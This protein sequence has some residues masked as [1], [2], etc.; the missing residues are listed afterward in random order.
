MSDKVWTR[1]DPLQWIEADSL[2][3]SNLL[4]VAVDPNYTYKCYVVNFPY[5]DVTPKVVPKVKVSSQV[6]LRKHISQVEHRRSQLPGGSL[7]SDL[8]LILWDWILAIE[9]SPAHEEAI[10]NAVSEVALLA[11]TLPSSCPLVMAKVNMVQT[12]LQKPVVVRDRKFGSIVGFDRMGAKDMAIMQLEQAGVST[13]PVKVIRPQTLELYDFNFLGHYQNECWRFIFYLWD[14]GRVSSSFSRDLAA[15]ESPMALQPKFGHT[16]VNPNMQI[17]CE[18]LQ[19][20]SNNAFKRVAVGVSPCC[21]ATGL[22]KSVQFDMY[23]TRESWGTLL[24]GLLKNAR[25]KTRCPLV[26]SISC[27]LRHSDD[28]STTAGSL[29]QDSFNSLTG[30]LLSLNEFATSSNTDGE[31]YVKIRSAQLV[32]YSVLFVAFS[33]VDQDF[34]LPSDSCVVELWRGTTHLASC[35]TNSTTQYLKFYRGG[36]MLWKIGCTIRRIGPAPVPLP[37]QNIIEQKHLHRSLAEVRFDESLLEHFKPFAHALI[38]LLSLQDSKIHEQA[39]ANLVTLFEMVTLLNKPWYI[40]LLLPTVDLKDSENF[41]VQ[42]VALLKY[43]PSVQ[44]VVSQLEAIC[45]LLQDKSLPFSLLEKFMCTLGSAFN[46][47]PDVQEMLLRNF[48]NVANLSGP[49]LLIACLD[50]FKFDSAT[51]SVE[52]E[53]LFLLSRLSRLPLGRHKEFTNICINWMTQ[54]WNQG[55]KQWY[56]FRAVTSIMIHPGFDEFLP[57]IVD[58]AAV[59]CREKEFSHGQIFVCQREDA[60]ENLGTLSVEF[61]LVLFN[62]L[63]GQMYSQIIESLGL[64]TRN[65]IRILA[66]KILRLCQFYLSNASF[67]N[68]WYTLTV[69]KLGTL[70]KLL[71][72]LLEILSR[73]FI[74]RDVRNFDSSLW[75]DLINSICKLILAPQ[76]HESSLSTSEKVC[77]AKTLPGTSDHALELLERTWEMLAPN[78]RLEL[79][80]CDHSITKPFLDLVFIHGEP[81]VQELVA[82]MVQSMMDAELTVSSNLNQFYCEIIELTDDLFLRLKQRKASVPSR[83]TCNHFF[84]LFNNNVMWRLRNYVELL[85]DNCEY[86]T[87]LTLNRVMQQLKEEKLYNLYCRY[88]GLLSESEKNPRA[89]GLCFRELASLIEFSDQLLPRCIHPPMPEQKSSERR[90]HL[91]KMASQCFQRGKHWHLAIDVSR[92]LCKW[93][94]ITFDFQECAVETALL[95]TFY[96]NAISE[97][98]IAPNYY[99]VTLDLFGESF[100][101]ETRPDLRIEEFKKQIRQSYKCDALVRTIEPVINLDSRAVMPWVAQSSGL[102]AVTQFSWSQPMEHNNATDLWV[103]NAIY[104]VESPLPTIC[105][106]CAVID[107]EVTV[108]SPANHALSVVNRKIEELKTI[109]SQYAILG[110]NSTAI[111]LELTL[112]GILDSPINGGIKSYQQFDDLSLR[113]ALSR[114]KLQIKTSLDLYKRIIDR[115]RLERYQ[116]FVVQLAALPHDS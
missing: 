57:L 38:R 100:V 73:Y 28:P 61:M 42:I 107:T 30:A 94:E 87:L 55:S 24:S 106:S 7:E 34:F 8:P 102:T 37:V 47:N 58:A 92:Q 63:N 59:L 41:L 33:G 83:T 116:Q 95:S 35:T 79:C 40:E 111:R 32:V 25:T 90:V 27:S 39:V 50:A 43:K 17:V 15:H 16:L 45:K 81:H 56:K 65:K 77:L 49:S 12:M 4:A 74:P 82:T 53:R 29:L 67:P 18:I 69:I 99:F 72:Y 104:T 115:S 9:S 21:D 114:L 1:L 2:N 80:C 86:D 108:I 105:S 84:S 36:K 91:L 64:M 89:L 5:V 93:Y 11:K 10:L 22:L 68:Y 23:C 3:L 52:T 54:L 62:F 98:T 97:F 31:F 113:D 48:L 51:D 103:E 6:T 20:Q 85:I 110:P 19:P 78:I 70:G 60:L 101:C 66:V 112:S 75:Y 88:V 13:K 26:E 14:G 96:T 44:R 46:A 71:E 76:I 109:I